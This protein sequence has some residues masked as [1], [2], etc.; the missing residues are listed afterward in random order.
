MLLDLSP[1]AMQVLQSWDCLPPSLL[2]PEGLNCDSHMVEVQQR[3]FWVNEWSPILLLDAYREPD[4]VNCAAPYRGCVIPNAFSPS[5]RPVCWKVFFFD[6]KKFNSNKA[7]YVLKGT[8]TSFFNLRLQGKIMQYLSSC[9]TWHIWS[10]VPWCGGREYVIPDFC[11]IAIHG[12][13]LIPLY[14]C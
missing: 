8:K 9:E 12:K 5:L 1:W 4:L 2:Y 10:P 3:F 7:F 11:R 14:Q 6:L 13:G